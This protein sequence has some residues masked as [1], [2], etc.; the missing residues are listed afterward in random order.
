MG[1][2]TEGKPRPSPGDDPSSLAGRLADLSAVGLAL[3]DGLRC[4]ADEM[5]SRRLARAARDLADRVERGESLADAIEAGGRALPPHLREL[6]MAS[7]KSG[8]M[9]TVLG[10]FIAYG[11]IGADLRRGLA[12]GLLYPFLIVI[13]FGTLMA[14]MYGL[15]VPQFRMIYEEFNI[16][17]PLVTQ[18]LLQL[19]QL[20]GDAGWPPVLKFLGGLAALFAAWRLLLDSRSRQGIVRRIPLFGA[21]FRWTALSEFCH[22]AGVLLDAEI[23]IDRALVLAADATDDA[24]LAESVRRASR[25]LVGGRSLTDALT[26]VPSVSIPRGVGLFLGWAE[27]R[28][29]LPESFHTLGDLFAAE[30][31][32]R[33]AVVSAVVVVLVVVVVIWVVGFTVVGLFLPLIRLI[34]VLSG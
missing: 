4:L 3:P 21:I 22:Y 29:A 25:E 6:L 13:G 1:T 12:I 31:R 15:V 2:E 19:T 17:V 28:H 34:S 18:A 11:R 5:P 14:L 32:G 9:G 8:R 30:A 10:E 27:G 23:P 24:N 16:S 33:A 20:F 26:T 7:I